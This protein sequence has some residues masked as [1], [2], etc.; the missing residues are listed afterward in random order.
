[1]TGPEDPRDE[2]PAAAAA[3]IDCAA[4][5]AHCRAVC[6]AFEVPLTPADR[7]EGAARPDPARPGWLARAADGWCVHLDRATR[8]CTIHARRPRACRTYACADDPDIWRDFAARV[9][10]P[11]GVERLL[12]LCRRRPP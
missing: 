10:D 6:C 3:A 2:P 5:G 7:A 11:E 12:A 9:A 1:M 8:A 4:R